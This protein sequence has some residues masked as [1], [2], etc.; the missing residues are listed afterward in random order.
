MRFLTFQL[1]L[2]SSCS[3]VILFLAITIAH[4]SGVHTA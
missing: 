4:V 1:V 3:L 2:T